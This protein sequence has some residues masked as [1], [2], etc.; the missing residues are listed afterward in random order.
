MNP[1][2]LETN[3]TLAETIENLK[4][5]YEKSYDFSSVA[6]QATFVEAVAE[7]AKTI[8]LSGKSASIKVSVGSSGI[9][10]L[11]VES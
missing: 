10:T 9:S 6:D 4:S 2:L 7:F 8:A 3:P 1:A 5:A 11:V